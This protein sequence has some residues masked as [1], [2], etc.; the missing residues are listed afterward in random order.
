VTATSFLWHDY[1][2]FGRDAARER[3]AQ[4]AAIRT[5][6]ELE[7]VDDPVMMYCRQSTDYLPDPESCLIHG[8]LPQT[9][10][11]EGSTEWDFACS[12]NRMMSQPGTCTAGYNNIRFDDEFTRQLLFRNLLDPYAREWSNGNSRWDLIDVVRL[13]RALRPQGIEWP[14][15]NDGKP[16][17]KLE[18]LTDAN[19]IAHDNAHDAMSDV[20]A[21]IA[22]AKLIRN[23]QP[24]LYDFAFSARKKVATMAALSLVSKPAAL[25]VSGMYSS[26]F[27]H[28][29]IVMPL[30][31]HPT[32]ANGILV[33]D[34]RN[35]PNDII[36]CSKE[37]I[38]DRLFTPQS[39]LPVDVSRIS[40]KTVHANRC[41]VIAPLSVLTDENAARLKL[42]VNQALQYRDSLIKAGA[43][44]SE[45][46]AWAFA[47]RDYPHVDDP[48]L[49]LYSG[50]FASDRD[51]KL[52]QQLQGC[53]AAGE[54]PQLPE[55]DDRRLLEI[56]FRV[57]ARSHPHLL[58]EGD[59][60]KWSAFCRSRVHQGI[61]GFRNHD[62]FVKSLIKLRASHNDPNSQHIFNNLEEYGQMVADYSRLE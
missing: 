3:P 41:P 9:A 54:T 49:T 18:L 14:F 16:T 7:E 8:V 10:N 20:H 37:E 47:A 12:I 50:N 2:T 33:Y 22:I 44:V 17:N 29:S 55:F 58:S 52:M 62:N 25:H 46:L 21:T 26:E 36:K 30:G 53:L 31:P 28:T 42:D 45:K 1:E 38:A 19:G 11:R 57:K 34:L 24:R 43:Q 6:D 15:D 32:N 51:R 61:D 5:N 59:T 60:G 13:T 40:V 4:F 35:S 56:Y 39:E 23:K 48:E 27:A